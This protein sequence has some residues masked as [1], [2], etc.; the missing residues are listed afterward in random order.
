M[1][2]LVTGGSGFVGW[3]ILNRLATDYDVWYTYFQNDVTH[4]IAT[5]INL[6]IRNK[7]A[8][9]ECINNICPDVIIHSAAMT[10]VDACETNPKQAHTINVNGTK[11]ILDVATDCDASVVFLSTAFVFDGKKSEYRPND[12]RNPINK[13]GQTKYEAEKAVE[14][15]DLRTTILRI[16][17]PYGRVQP[18]QSE[19]MIQ[20][21][22]AQLSD[23]THVEVFDDWHNNPTYI[24]DISKVIKL[25]V[26]RTS[27][28]TFHVV[29]PN[30]ISRFSW[31]KLIADAFGYDS[32]RIVPSHSKSVNLP[33]KRPN[34]DLD[35]TTVTT[36]L[37][38]SMTEIN[39][40]LKEMVDS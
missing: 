25:V 31:A 40:G 24:F 8:V 6:D 18:W 37:K 12:N 20:W 2:I 32:S 39:M 15:S 36:D 13:Y 19:T 29:G 14:D 33:A 4:P 16:D 5:G 17:Q 3:S 30:Y 1:K 23:N 26:E 28:G 10:D 38:L 7:K 35:N 11:N 9:F 21:T 27:T 34:V 22:L